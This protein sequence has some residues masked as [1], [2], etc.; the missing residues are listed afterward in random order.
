[1]RDDIQDLAI[2]N[3]E[4][5]MS[6]D[7]PYR[8][9]NLPT[10]DDFE[11]E[12]NGIFDR[13]YYTNHGV[14]VQKL[15]EKLSAF[16]NVNN[17][18]CVTNE[19]IG[20]MMILKA[21]DLKGR[22]AIPAFTNIQNI[23]SLLWV[24]LTPVFCDVDPKT[25]FLSYESIKGVDQIE[26]IS[27]IVNVNFVGNLFVEK[28][29]MKY[30]KEKNI[31]IISDSS[32]SFGC[33]SK[34]CNIS[35]DMSVFSFY[36]SQIINTAQGGCIAINDNDLAETIRNIRSSY[37]AR[38]SVPIEVTS[39]GRM[40]EAQAALGL[41]SLKDYELNNDL[42]KSAFN[43]YMDELRDLPINFINNS[44][45]VENNYQNLAIAI[46]DDFGVDP[47]KVKKILKKENLYSV[48]YLYPD[49]NLNK[50]Y[51]DIDL[52]PNSKNLYNKVIHLPNTNDHIIIKHVCNLLRLIYNNKNIL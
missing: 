7:F 50:N 37:G 13:R 35:N 52:F 5:L 25:G 15:E 40:S 39:N 32:H 47:H 17:V 30:A 22:V 33:N 23:E 24:G 28:D 42:N 20:M 34:N 6:K 12:F 21:L 14:L 16:L 44:K 51:I 41:I 9:K 45:E 3:N 31:K 18:L 19:M 38:K 8:S 43:L 4:P 27:A 46:K 49:I 11:K 29:L 10:W 36:K 1:M 2:F 48:D 26:S